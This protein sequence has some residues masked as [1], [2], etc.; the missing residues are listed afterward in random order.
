MSEGY[1]KV[2]IDNL[3]HIL[4]EIQAQ[5]ADQSPLKQ[6]TR[7]IHVALNDAYEKHKQFIAQKAQKDIE[8]LL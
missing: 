1:L 8:D 5:V 7:N 2:D 6:A 3:R 4:D